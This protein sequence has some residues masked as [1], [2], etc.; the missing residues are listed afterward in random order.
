MFAATN[1]APKV[2]VVRLGIG[3]HG[4]EKPE[5]GL[6]MGLVPSMASM[7]HDA[8]MGGYYVSN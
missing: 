8:I 4:Y 3:T 7:W 1:P 6:P 5:D 2:N